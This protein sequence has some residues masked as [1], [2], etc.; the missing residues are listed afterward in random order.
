MKN[1]E[2]IDIKRIAKALHLSRHPL[3]LPPTLSVHGFDSLARFTNSALIHYSG[4]CVLLAT[5]VYFNLLQGKKMVSVK[6]TPKPFLGLTSDV[7][8][9]MIFGQELDF[10]EKGMHSLLEVKERILQ[11]YQLTG[12]LYYLI[13]TSGYRIPITG[14][15]GHDFNAAVINDGTE[16]LYI[17]AW[18]TSQH[19]T[20]TDML[21]HRFNKS[22]FFDIKVLPLEQIRL[23]GWTRQ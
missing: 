23:K 4:N 20:T 16:V 1:S 18:K 10:L 2:N 9:K 19:V 6:N 17:D 3:I 14:G 5:C 8:E 22:A 7:V 21:T 13:S 15:S 11:E 12:R